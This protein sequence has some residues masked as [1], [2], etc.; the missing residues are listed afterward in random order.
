MVPLL[1]WPLRSRSGKLV[2]REAHGESY[3]SSGPPSSWAWGALTL[4][5]LLGQRS[6]LRPL[7]YI[8]PQLLSPLGGGAEGV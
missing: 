3:Q 7:P 5:S 8:H 4:T 2:R 6:E 1:A